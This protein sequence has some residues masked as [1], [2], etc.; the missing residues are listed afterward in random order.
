M[1]RA[2]PATRDAAEDY[3]LALTKR[4]RL[5]V[6]E[7][8]SNVKRQV[9]ESYAAYEESHGL[10]S[11]LEPLALDDDAASA[12]K[13][14]YSLT[15]FGSPL[16]GIRNQA[17]AATRERL[18]PLCGKGY[19]GELDHYLPKEL[20]PE[21]SILHFN[22]VPACERCNHNKRTLIGSAAEG[23]FLHPYF[24]RIPEADPVLRVM[25]IVEDR[26]VVARFSVN[27]ILPY[28]LRLNASYH[29]DK[30]KL[31]PLYA[32]GS[33]IEMIE[34][35]G[36]ISKAY[37]REGAEGVARLA[38]ESAA[39]MRRQFGVHYWK[40][41]LYDGIAASRAFCDGGFRLLVRAG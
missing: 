3:D 29:F 5:V 1:Y 8:L 6:R 21:F 26:A 16:E 19:A 34:R 4:R 38:E 25:M 11:K 2:T 17:F 39:D 27:E 41:A 22:L 10:A 31:R 14:N 12:L 37:R 20:Y 32:S 40:V 33:A 35:Y 23:R 15:L 9:L 36:A 28:D 30:L 18:C 24:D 7:Q 13:G